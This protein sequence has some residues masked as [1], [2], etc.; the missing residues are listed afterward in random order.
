LG[1][2]TSRRITGW[3]E[4]GGVLGLLGHL[5]LDPV[6]GTEPLIESEVIASVTPRS[7]TVARGVGVGFDLMGRTEVEDDEIRRP[8]KQVEDLSTVWTLLTP[9]HHSMAENGDVDVERL[10]PDVERVEPAHTMTSVIG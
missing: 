4:T 6:P 5:G 10:Q 1:R 2:E 8:V 3:L 7:R 9:A